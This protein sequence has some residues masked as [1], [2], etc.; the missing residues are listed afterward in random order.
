MQTPTDPAETRPR[1]SDL[2]RL[3]NLTSIGMTLSGMILL[4]VILF[5][6]WTANSSATAREMALWDNALNRSILRTLNEQKSV[7]WWDDAYK[8]VTEPALAEEFIENEFGLFLSETYG[9]D[10]IAVVNGHN[11]PVFLYSGGTRR[12]LQEMESYRSVIAPIVAEMRETKG[13]ALRARPDLFGAT[14]TNYR[15]IGASLGT[16]R[17]TG[18]IMTLNGTPAIVAALTILPNVDMSLLKEGRP[19]ILLSINFIDETYLQELGRTLLLSDFSFKPAPSPSQEYASKPLKTDDGT[20]AGYISWKTEQPGRS[21]TYIILPLVAVGFAAAAGLAYSMLSRLRHTSTHLAQEEERS[22][23]AAK[24]DSLSGLPNRAHFAENLQSVLACLEPEASRQTAVVAYIDID[25]FKEVNDTLGHSAGDSLIQQVGQRLRTHVRQGDFIARYG[26][27][28]FA[29]LWLSANPAAPDLLASRIDRALVTPLQIE[30]QPVTVTASVGIAVAPLHGRT[31]DEVMRHAD[32]A[33]YEAKNAGRNRSILF[34]ADMA[35]LVEQRRAI[36]MDL[37]TAI[38]NDEINVAYQPIIRCNSREIVGVEALARWNHPERGFISPA[39]FIQVAEQSG[40]MPALGERVM[41]RA[42]QD[43]HAWPHLDV[44][45]NLSPLQF[46]Q[47]DLVSILKRL[48]S[49]HRI[50]PSRFILEITEGV[51]MDAGERTRDVLDHIRSLGYRMAL[52]DFGTGYSSLAYLCNFRFDK[53][54]IDRSFVGGLSRSPDVRTIVRSVIALGR[55]LGMETVAEG[56]ETQTEA[57]AMS[58]FGC[59]EMQGYYFARPMSRAALETFIASYEP[60]PIAN[61]H[62]PQ[63]AA[64]Q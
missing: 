43:W 60:S 6:A 39:V 59:S 32:I 33:L 5:A 23:Y 16:A 3:M 38:A 55:G 22:R 17:W 24:H 15:T 44:S 56:V 34:S 58:E 30:G 64:A 62:R 4:A 40:L 20:L 11:D 10:V 19:Y 53:I 26:G 36:E 8:A 14:Q 41:A 52:D 2:R 12:E 13:R 50:E 48:A 9:H 18:H 25:R 31:V 61:A 29:I 47:S 63:V 37:S 27:D 46:R 49:E 28:E 57:E 54:K 1:E 42:M 21:L 45:I 35:E 51:L 7:A